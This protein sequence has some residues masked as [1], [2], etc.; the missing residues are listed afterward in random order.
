MTL[1]YQLIRERFEI[2]RHRPYLFYFIGT[3]V[4]MFGTGMQ[5]IA[6]SWLAMELTGASFS[7]AVVLVCSAVP[8]IVLSPFVGVFVDRWDR[9]WLSVCMDFFRAV[10]LLAVPI[11]W[12]M[13][14]LQAWHLYVMAFFIALG[15][16]VY[17]PSTMALIREVI[18]KE[19]LLSAN[20]FSSI[21]NQIGGLVGAGAAGLIIA[22]FSPMV[23]MIVNA[24]TFIFSAI[25]LLAMRRGV[26]KPVRSNG[27]GGTWK[28]FLGEL[29]DGFTYIRLH[30]EIIPKYLMVLLFIATLRT[31]N[32]IIAPFALNELEVGTNGFGFIDASFGIGALIGGLVLPIATRMYGEKALMPFGVLAMGVSLVLFSLSQNLWMAVVGYSLIGIT[33]QTRILYL[34]EAQK[35][36]GLE[37]QGRVYSTFNTFFSFTSLVVYM[38]MGFIG[39]I[40][41]YRWLYAVQGGIVATVGVYAYKSYRR[42]DI[43]TQVNTN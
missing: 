39:E 28:K 40:F 23:I 9:R 8:G 41:S 5:F 43:F 24:G 27:K 20:S 19:I 11:L 6:N 34:T 4:S 37:Y 33:F 2:F 15:D 18:P 38:V 21:A 31:I 10:I 22:Y 3:T 7:V 30:R 35:S 25:C 16:Q 26:I 13:G 12:W 36:T 1:M 42:K 17:N 14:Q 32:V 29:S